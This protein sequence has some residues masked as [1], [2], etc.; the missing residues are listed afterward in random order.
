MLYRKL[1]P[2]QSTVLLMIGIPHLHVR[3]QII[4]EFALDVNELNQ[5]LQ[6]IEQAQKQQEQQVGEPTRISSRQDI[7]L[8]SRLDTNE[9]APLSTL[10]SARY[11]QRTPMKEMVLKRMS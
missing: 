8:S 7:R 4:Q 1:L 2:D 9:D 3:K 11:K 10:T 6:V 5:E